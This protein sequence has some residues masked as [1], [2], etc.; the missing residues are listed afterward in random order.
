MRD[1]KNLQAILLRRCIL[2]D[3]ACIEII[4]LSCQKLTSLYLGN[5]PLITDKS[6]ASLGKKC[7]NLKSINVTGT[8]VSQFNKFLIQKN[9]L[10]F[11]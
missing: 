2:V 11:N 3:D 4:A 1:C 10:D 5:C 7:A 9:N 6:L 8:K